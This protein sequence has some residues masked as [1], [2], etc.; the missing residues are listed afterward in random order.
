MGGRL[1]SNIGTAHPKQQIP[2]IIYQ[3]SISKR[4]TKLGFDFSYKRRS[5]KKHQENLQGEEAMLWIGF[6]STDLGDGA[7]TARCTVIIG[8]GGKI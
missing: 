7:E 2:E 3:G 4:Q 8:N 5:E 1:D 6:D